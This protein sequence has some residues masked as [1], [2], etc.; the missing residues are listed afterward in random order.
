MKRN[1]L[2]FLIVYIL[3]TGAAFGLEPEICGPGAQK[4]GW[5]AILAQFSGDRMLPM[6]YPNMR[7]FTLP[8]LQDSEPKPLTKDEE[9]KV[10]E[11]T[12]D[13]LG[14]YQ[15]GHPLLHPFYKTAFKKLSCHCHTGR[16]RPSRVQ[17][18]Q[19]SENNTTGVRVL[20]NGQMCDV[21]PEALRRDQSKI[22][23]SLLL[24]NVHVCVGEKGCEELECVI[25]GPRSQLDMQNANA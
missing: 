19:V 24:F 1:G 11:A 4:S 14:N 15:C 17:Y 16:C 21:P 3:T 20:A 23:A 25:L 18:V 2:I 12:K 6:P 9:E 7:G 8:S 5:R 10:L 13:C 22:P